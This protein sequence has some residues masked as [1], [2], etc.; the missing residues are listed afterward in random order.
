[1]ELAQ[2]SEAVKKF[3]ANVMKRKASLKIYMLVP[4]HVI[5]LKIPLIALKHLWCFK[6]VAYVGTRF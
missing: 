4:S 2:L 1:M 3:I 5:F 6:T